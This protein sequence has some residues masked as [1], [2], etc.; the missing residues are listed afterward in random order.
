[1]AVLIRREVDDGVRATL[2]FLSKVDFSPFF[3]SWFKRF[4]GESNL[5]RG[6]FKTIEYQIWWINLSFSF[7]K[8]GVNSFRVTL[9]Y[10]LCDF[11]VQTFTFALEHCID[12]TQKCKSKM[13][14]FRFKTRYEVFVLCLIL[15]WSTSRIVFVLEQRIS[16]ILQLRVFEPQRIG[17]MEIKWNNRNNGLFIK[18]FLSET[19]FGSKLEVKSKTKSTLLSRYVVLLGNYTRGAI[20]PEMCKINQSSV[21]FHCKPLYSLWLDWFIGFVP[22]DLFLR[23]RGQNDST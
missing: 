18:L 20:F 5:K 17:I 9:V 1:M 3:R 15:K 22:P 6:Y 12:W 19:L 23:G 2:R 10:G 11:L 13:A 8:E 4:T 16:V 7:V 21:D 14:I